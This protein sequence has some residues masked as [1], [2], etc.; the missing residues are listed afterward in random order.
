MGFEGDIPLRFECFKVSL[1]LSFSLAS[2]Q[3]LSPKVF[4]KVGFFLLLFLS[5]QVLCMYI[6]M[7]SGFVFFQGIFVYTDVC[8]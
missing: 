2:L 5:C 4:S 8:L 7:T 3:V 1:S 6:M